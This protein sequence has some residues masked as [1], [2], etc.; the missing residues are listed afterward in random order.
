MVFGKFKEDIV[1][2]KGWASNKSIKKM[3]IGLALWTLLVAIGLGMI[4]LC[5]VGSLMTFVVL[6]LTGIG[7][8]WVFDLADESEEN[9]KLVMKVAKFWWLAVIVDM[10]IFF[11]LKIFNFI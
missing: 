2:E 7:F 8:L 4:T 10:G 6:I 9:L 5:T 11:V 1:V 3:T